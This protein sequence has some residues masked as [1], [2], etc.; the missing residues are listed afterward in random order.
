MVVIARQSKALNRKIM[1]H[2]AAAHAMRVNA[3][4][5]LIKIA[6]WAVGRCH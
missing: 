3:R 1:L 2:W 4:K 5:T 6:C